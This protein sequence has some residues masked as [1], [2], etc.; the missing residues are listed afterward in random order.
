MAQHSFVVN[1]FDA[2]TSLFSVL[3]LKMERYSRNYLGENFNSNQFY[4]AVHYQSDDII[5]STKFRE[6]FFC[7]F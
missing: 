5:D 7:N 6:L 2:V 4:V 1:L 3:D